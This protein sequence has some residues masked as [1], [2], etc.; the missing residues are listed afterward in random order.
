MLDHKTRDQVAYASGSDAHVTLTHTDEELVAMLVRKESRALDELYDRYVRLVFSLALKMLRDRP[1]AE[2]IVQDVFVRVWSRA[3]EFRP[4]RASF[5]TW[6]LGISH[7]RCVDEIRRRRNYHV[8][9][10]SD[11]NP[12][13]DLSDDEMDPA[14]QA[15][16]FFDR[17]RIQ[18]A[19]AQLPTEQRL[20]VQLAYFEGLTHQEIATRCEI[21]LGTAKTRINLAM[22]KLKKILQ[23]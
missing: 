6:L 8:T 12:E 14:K 2:E 20:A 4:E 3:A 1:T 19:L 10:L 15:Q 13:F 22:R 5:S 7:H 18:R 9:E 16:F 23:D 21:P 11:E 17:D